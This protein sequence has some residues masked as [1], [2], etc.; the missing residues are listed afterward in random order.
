MNHLHVAGGVVCASLLLATRA[1]AEILGGEP[2][3]SSNPK[4]NV[5]KEIQR[6]TPGGGTFGPGGSG[7]GTRS[8]E[9]VGMKKEKPEPVTLDDLKKNVEKTHG[10]G[11]AIAAEKLKEESIQGAKNKKTRRQNGAADSPS[12][13]GPKKDPQTFRQL[14][15]D[16][17]VQGQELVNGQPMDKQQ[18]ANR[19]ASERGVR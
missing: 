4:D 7:P 13:D 18:P 6:S 12:S 3:T 5:P 2:G 15:S 9:L 16:K 8:D 10:G 17:S 14:N 11:S 1:Y 19:P